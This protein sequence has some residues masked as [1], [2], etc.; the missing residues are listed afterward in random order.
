MFKRLLSL[1]VL[2]RLLPKGTKSR[3]F[4]YLLKLILGKLK[5]NLNPDEIEAIRELIKTLVNLS[6]PTDFI[7]PIY[8]DFILDQIF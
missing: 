1:M 4:R 7:L 2:Q 8:L 3:L 5:N 6:N